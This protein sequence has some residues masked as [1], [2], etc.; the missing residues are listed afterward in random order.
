[1]KKIHVDMLMTVEEKAQAVSDAHKHEMNL[2]QYIRWLVEKE[3]KEME[4]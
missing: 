1:M 3:R 4:K 2:S